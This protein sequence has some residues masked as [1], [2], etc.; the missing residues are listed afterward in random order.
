MTMTITPIRSNNNAVA[1]G[2]VK[3]KEVRKT[4]KAL[5]RLEVDASAAPTGTKGDL[6]KVQK[7]LKQLGVV[8]KPAAED[9]QK[10]QKKADR[11]AKKAEKAAKKIE[12][13]FGI[14]VLD[15]IK[16]AIT[17]DAGSGKVTAVDTAAIKEAIGG[18]KGSKKLIKKLEKKFGIEAEEAVEKSGKKAAKAA[19]QTAAQG[20][21]AETK[22]SFSKW[23]IGGAIAVG[24]VALAYLTGMFGGDKK[25]QQ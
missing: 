18:K 15:K 12:K 24:A 16:A 4:L 14:G 19:E 17:V 21:E 7:F 22:S 10:L 3:P 13:K 25:A 6:K 23:L 1:F 20:E 11:A 9:A 8:L 5:S 2:T